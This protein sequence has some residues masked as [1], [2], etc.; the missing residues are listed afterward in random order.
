VRHSVRGARDGQCDDRNLPFVREQEERKADLVLLLQDRW[1]R[2]INRLGRFVR[3]EFLFGVLGQELFNLQMSMKTVVI[4]TRGSKLA[5]WQAEHVRSRLE[6]RYP[7]IGIELNIIKTTGDKILDVPLAKVGGKGLFVKEIEE[8]LL[9]GKADLAVHSMKDVPS[10]LPEGLKLGIIPERAAA[11]DLLLSTIHDGIDRLP[12]AAKVGTSSLRRQSQLL[13]LRPDLEVLTLRGNL[14][15][16]VRKLLDGAFDAIVVAAAGMDRLGLSVPK[17]VPLTP[18]DFYPAVGQ[19]AL[20][21]EYGSD[22]SDLDEL[23]GFMDHPPTRFCVL[24]ERAF[25]DTL[26][27]GCQ[28]PI[29]GH[30]VFEDSQ[31]RLA[32]RV[33]EL[34]GSLIV[35]RELRGKAKDAE[36]LGKALA[37][38]I[39][40]NGG[41]EILDKVYGSQD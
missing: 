8:A 7:G 15:T 24:A 21:I 19:G 12:E 13:A 26:E 27:G 40:Q 17:R 32:G 3:R 38:D 10:E 29:A 18:P 30:A 1:S 20:G 36:S 41:R 16:R 22:R 2:R 35:H 33:A 39:L 34:D 25:L 31:L 11:H 28:V 37:I 23:L 6:Q 14:D 4:A 5:L 9:E